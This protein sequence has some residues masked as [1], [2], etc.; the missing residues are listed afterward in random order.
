M[1]SVIRPGRGDITTTRSDRYTASGI[2]WVTNTTVVCVAAQIRS[3]S[4][5]MC[6]RVISSSAPNG[7][8]I[9]SSGGWAARARAMATR[10]CMPPESCHGMC[11]AKSPSLT[12]SSISIARVPAL[13]LV[14]ALQLQ[15][16]LDVLLDGAPV[17]QPG[18]LERHAVVLVEPGLGGR[19]AVD[20][21]PSPTV[22]SIRLAIRRSS[23]DLPQP[24][25]P[26]SDTNS[27]GA[28][29]RST[30]TSASTWFGRARVEHL[31]RRSTTTA[32]SLI[33]PAS[34]GRGRLRISDR[35][36]MPTTARTSRARATAA[37]KTPGRPWSGRPW[38]AGQ[39]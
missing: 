31:R 11:S 18:L 38:P 21:A 22:G 2:E 27:P 28:T 1:M 16:Q 19:L 36:S 17:E 25:G 13:G 37:P 26:I 5:C 32:G 23:V 9:S 35:S 10:C 33:A 30:S 29:V 34:A 7:S 39:Y 6:S 24:D 8:S 14:P 12:S 20:D 4:A 15:R 3:S